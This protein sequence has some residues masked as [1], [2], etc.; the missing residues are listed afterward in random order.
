MLSANKPMRGSVI[1]WEG[2]VLSSSAHSGH[3][4]KYSSN[5]AVQ[6]NVRTL[7]LLGV[8]D[9]VIHGLGSVVMFQGS[10]WSCLEMI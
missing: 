9:E 7:E 1:F 5:Q 4:W 2:E 3:S 10:T 6:L 8:C